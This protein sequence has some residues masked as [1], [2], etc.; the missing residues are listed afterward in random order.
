MARPRPESMAER[1]SS[2]EVATPRA[3]P[4][5]DEAAT[6]GRAWP[7][8]HPWLTLL[9]VLA[10]A[11]VVLVL[12]WDWNWFK[13]PIEYVVHART[14][15][16]LHLDGNLD[17][18]LGRMTRVSVERLRFANAGW[19]EEKEMAKAER[20][21]LA[22]ELFPALFRRD[23][24]VPELRLTRP[25]LLLEIGPDGV[26]N[27]V[28][29]NRQDSRGL[30]P[31]F[32]RLWI[33]AG[34][35]R[36]EDPRSR[37]GFDVAVQ[38]QPPAAR[39]SGPPISVRGKGRWKGSPFTLQ[40]RGESPLDLR[41][42]D[43]PYTVDVRASAGPTHAHARGTLLDP[44]RLRDFDLQLAL[45]GQ[46]LEDLYPLLG[47]AIPATPPYTLDG[48]LTR[49]VHSPQ[50]STWKYDGFTGRVGDS[51][52]SGFAHFTTGKPRPSLKADLRSRR[53]DM[54]DLAGFI[55]GAPAAG[56]GERTNPEL[57]A[58]AA[59]RAASPRLFPDEPFR[60]DKLRAMDADVRFR[61]A[62]INTRRL[63]LDDMDAKLD[64]RAGLLTL[65]PL[66]FGVADGDV[67][68]TIRLDARE[69][70]IR[71]RANI[72]AS[73]LTLGKLLPQVKL[74][75]NALG[76]VGGDVD[77]D[78]HGNSIAAMMAHADGQAQAGMGE[79]RISKLLMEMAAIDIAGIL[80]IKLTHDRQIP[81]RCAFADFSVQ[82]G[83]MATRSLAFDTSETVILG[84]GR[85][86]LRQER[87]ALVLK[88]K[89]RRFSPLSLRAPLHLEGTF[90]DPDLRPDYTRVG[91]RAA[92]AALLGTATAPAAAL[93]A[94]A[95][96]GNA[97]AQRYCGGSRR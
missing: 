63:P 2:E 53:L 38:S 25:D 8:R 7:R 49:V 32:R 83:L 87:L 12:L 19:A 78:T 10:A 43:E 41:D 14:G 93:V 89:T 26:G 13:R 79:G 27:W 58:K 97:K 33:E 21:D 75:R 35:L 88:P 80:K 94:T 82:D 72:R 48:R 52:L 96:P 54:D 60:L 42:P 74:G 51:D 34:H 59:A 37:T 69:S 20:L 66:N 73:G 55:G 22:F 65:T 3:A 17:V 81:I 4:A 70:T 64:L 1:P 9:G 31:Q 90:K 47:L 92:T 15:R 91:L 24:R 23:F 29:K 18:D 11:V 95:D 39:D 46:N 68:S 62:R 36:F 67:R 40:G 50:R 44:L 6:R 30:Q 57:A 16:E 45:S 77:I 76:K 56:Q 61:A 84:D 85:L 28:L 71:T 86:D 5:S